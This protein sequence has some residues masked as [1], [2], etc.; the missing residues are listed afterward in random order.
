MTETFSAM[1]VNLTRSEAAKTMFF[2][3]LD[4][5]DFSSAVQLLDK[6]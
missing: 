1:V 2:V 6:P 5:L 4:N 3:A